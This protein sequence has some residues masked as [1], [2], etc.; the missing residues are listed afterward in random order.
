MRE[1]VVRQHKLRNPQAERNLFV[2]TTGS[3]GAAVVGD[4]GGEAVHVWS[5]SRALTNYYICFIF[6][7]SIRRF[8]VSSYVTQLCSCLTNRLWWSVN[9]RPKIQMC[10]C[11]VSLWS[12]FGIPDTCMFGY[13]GKRYNFK[14]IEMWKWFKFLKNYMCIPGTRQWSYLT[15]DPWTPGTFYFWQKL[16]I[17]FVLTLDFGVF[18]S[19]GE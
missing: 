2:F 4:G 12:E 9:L 3:I 19:Q 6:V 5:I 16:N 10:S 17:F 7:L 18:Y 8:L 15:V 13:F 14:A 11:V 1:C